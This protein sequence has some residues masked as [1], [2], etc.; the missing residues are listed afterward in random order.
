MKSVLEEKKELKNN[1][2]TNQLGPHLIKS[3]ISEE[4]E[5]NYNK[6]IDNLSKPY[7]NKPSDVIVSLLFRDK[8]RI[9]NSYKISPEP[10]TTALNKK[11]VLARMEPE[12]QVCFP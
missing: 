1:L 11:T 12:V 7:K 3:V 2:Y 5:K 6:V 10:L 8:E 4:I 9:R